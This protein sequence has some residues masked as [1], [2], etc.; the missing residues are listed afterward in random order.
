M[1]LFLKYLLILWK[2]LKTSTSTN[3][4]EAKRK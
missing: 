1:F 4:H 3:Y 2:G